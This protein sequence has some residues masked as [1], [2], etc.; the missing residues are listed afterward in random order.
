VNGNPFR[1]FSSSCG[2]R[3][4]DPLSPFIFVIVMEAL[5]KMISATVNGDFLLGF[6]VGSR[7]SCAVYLSH[8]LFV[9]DTLIFCRA[10]PN[11]LRYLCALFVC[12][13]A[14][15]GFSI[16]LAK[17]ELVPMGNVN[18]V[19][20]LAN[21]MGYEIFSLPLKYLDFTLGASFKAKY[22]WDG[23]IEK[24]ERCLAGWKMMYLS[25][26]GRITL[27]KRTIFN[28]PTYF[29]SLFPLLLG[30]ANHIEKLQRDSYGVG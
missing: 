27:I 17:S 11:H 21:I 3:P 2:L 22:I 8:L 25:K 29:M 14:V 1:F 16:N 20:G 28:L 15:F 18:N 23:V 26:S 6:S 12:F 10:N 19:D 30:V 5:S 24:I 13:E 7:N 4:R 9:D